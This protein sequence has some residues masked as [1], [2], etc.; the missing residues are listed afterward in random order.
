MHV[1]YHWLWVVTCL[2]VLQLIKITSNYFATSGVKD[3]TIDSK[4]CA[5]FY[6]FTSQIHKW[7]WFSLV[8]KNDKVRCFLFG[9]NI[10]L[11]EILWLFNQVAIQFLL[12]LWMY[13]AFLIGQVIAHMVSKYEMIQGYYRD[14]KFKIVI[15]TRDSKGW[16][17]Y[18]ILY[19]GAVF[20]ATMITF[21]FS[22][23][24][25]FISKYLNRNNILK[26]IYK[27]NKLFAFRFFN[28]T[29]EIRTN[30]H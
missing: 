15:H 4:V 2:C 12:L 6:L 14:T 22:L 7:I 13:H 20:I 19:G 9:E 27:S 23:K 3:V 1:P 5:F 29:I 28:H 18:D 25:S 24:N 8:I 26:L 10:T 17:T 30:Y 21:F 16:N 11:W